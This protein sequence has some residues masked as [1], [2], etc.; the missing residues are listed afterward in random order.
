MRA[1]EGSAGKRRPQLSSS[2]LAPVVR[3]LSSATLYYSAVSS[4]NYE[5]VSLQSL[6]VPRCFMVHVACSPAAVDLVARPLWTHF[7]RHESRSSFDIN[8]TTRGHRPDARLSSRRPPRPRKVC[9]DLS[10]LAPPPIVSISSAPSPSML[11]MCRPSSNSSRPS[12]YWKLRSSET[13]FTNSAMSRVSR[14]YPSSL[15][16]PSDLT[17]CRTC[18]DSSSSK[19]MSCHSA[20]LLVWSA[21]GQPYANSA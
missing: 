12:R 7:R 20:L 13:V 3:S 14:S 15:L 4:H 17:G 11:A 18:A 1:K 19:R 5:Y 2:P 10:R 8:V 9:T 16:P 21:L 6:H